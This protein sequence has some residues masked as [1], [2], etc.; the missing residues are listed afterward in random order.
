MD[1][2]STRFTKA[3]PLSIF[4]LL[5]VFVA[6][7]G[8]NDKKKRIETIT[9]LEHILFDE[10][11]DKNA[12]KDADKDASLNKGVS[13]QLEMENLRENYRQFLSS[14]SADTVS[15]RY[16]Y[17]WAM[18]EA[19]FFKNYTASVKLLE[20]FQR[21]YGTHPM[22]AKALFLQGFTYSEYLKDYKKA[23]L[24]YLAFI[25]RFPNH[26]LVPSIQF[27]LQNLGKSPEEL[28]NLKL[29]EAA[30]LNEPKSSKK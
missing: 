10:D 1:T 15:A 28:L 20:R 23:E 9:K 6:C 4:I 22:A 17:N 27:E 3:K 8:K 19:D 29:N 5:V 11:A 25:E 24:A 2:L 7:S 12:D 13:T 18:M 14:Y 26:D 30:S 16:V 21:D